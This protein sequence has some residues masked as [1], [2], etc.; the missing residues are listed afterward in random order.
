MIDAYAK[1]LM[2]QQHLYTLL[3]NTKAPSQISQK[4]FADLCRAVKKFHPVPIPSQLATQTTLSAVFLETQKENSIKTTAIYTSLKTTLSNLCTSDD[5]EP[6]LKQYFMALQFLNLN[7]QA[8][9]Q[10]FQ[11]QSGIQ[12]RAL[13]LPSL[14]PILVTQNTKVP[15]IQQLFYNML[16]VQLSA[17][18]LSYTF[19]LIENE[20]IY[21][22]L[23]L[24]N[25]LPAS[26]VFPEI[27]DISHI[28]EKPQ[29][30]SAPKTYEPHPELARRKTEAAKQ[31]LKNQYSPAITDATN[32]FMPVYQNDQPQPMLQPM[33]QNSQE[34]NPQ[35]TDA[36]MQLH[37]WLRLMH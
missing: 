19:T 23:W 24:K 10:A 16:Q 12:S 22:V 13:N 4:P 7:I 25:L 5:N 9:L 20:K 29:P 28:A 34:P 6:L 18:D 2:S 27:I 26:T 1:V 36:T 8:L 17:T 14:L 15:D 32:R 33:L 3:L 30:D 21:T 31:Q 35:P 37:P 11:S